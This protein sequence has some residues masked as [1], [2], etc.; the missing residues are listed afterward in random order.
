MSAST[1]TEHDTHGDAAA[2]HDEHAH[3]EHAHN[4]HAHKPN[5]Y[6]VQ[7]ALILAVLTA[8]ETSTYWVDFGP[9][10][11]PILLGLMAIKFFMV[12][13]IFMHLK[14]EKPIFKYLFFSGLGLAVFVYIFALFTVHFFS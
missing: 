10:F 9:A 2:A 1:V 12:V 14:D 7:I 8:I 6:Y 11:L 4:E 3:N 13:M 5:S